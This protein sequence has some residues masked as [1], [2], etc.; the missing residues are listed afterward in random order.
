MTVV[1]DFPED[2]AYSAGYQ[3][4]RRDMLR[5]VLALAEAHIKEMRRRGWINMVA[6]AKRLVTVLR[7]ELEAK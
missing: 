2:D 7:N 3:D 1:D 4:G 6:G 5:L